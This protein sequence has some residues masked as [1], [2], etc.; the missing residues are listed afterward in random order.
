[1]HG[2]TCGSKNFDLETGNTNVPPEL[3][4]FIKTPINAILI[5]NCN[6]NKALQSTN[7][8]KT[9][10]NVPVASKSPESFGLRKIKFCWERK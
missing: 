4:G 3:G 9:N 7:H 1:M 2:K 5:H 6:F 10:N 8:A